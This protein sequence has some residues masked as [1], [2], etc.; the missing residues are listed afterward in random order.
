MEIH[1]LVHRFF[2][3]QS[4]LKRHQEIAR[5]NK[6]SEALQKATQDSGGELEAIGMQKLPR[7]IQQMKNYR[8]TGYSKDHNL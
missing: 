2:V 7:N 3:Q 6:P 4:Q 5:T 1:V 8:R